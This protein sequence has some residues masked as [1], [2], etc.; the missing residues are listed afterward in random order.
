MSDL[1]FT[2]FWVIWRFGS[3]TNFDDLAVLVALA[4]LASDYYD[5][6][7]FLEFSAQFVLAD[8]TDLAD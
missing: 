6:F 7:A 1:Y 3:T 5:D 2:F 8:V 4:S